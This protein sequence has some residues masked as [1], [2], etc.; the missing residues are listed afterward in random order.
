MVTPPLPGQPM[1]VPNHSFG[2]AFPS[3]Q[4]EPSLVQ[5]E[6]ITS[7]P[8]YL[9]KSDQLEEEGEK[10]LLL[11]LRE[12]MSIYGPPPRTH[13]ECTFTNSHLIRVPSTHR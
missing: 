4:P 10:D 3:F 7:H 6:A 12:G 8:I 5:L 2:E 11:Q 1:P 9:A 13:A